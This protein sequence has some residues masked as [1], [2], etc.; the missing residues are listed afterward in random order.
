MFWLLIGL[1]LWCGFHLL[2]RLA[3]GA[4][5][6]IEAKAGAKG[7]RGVI[8]AG[9][10]AGLLLIVIGYRSSPFI[11]IYAPPAWTVHLNNLMMLLAV[12][13]FGASHSTGRIGTMFRHPQLLA[14][15]L[16]AV[17][18]LLVNGDLASILLFGVM[19][20]W[21]VYSMRLINAQDGPWA[22]RAPGPVK[23]DI[24]LV[25]I[26]L[27]VFGVIAMIHTLLGYSPFP[28]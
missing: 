13:L 3:P 1:A 24:I 22:R 19:L 6:G 12:G 8:A 18:H 9:I 28:G 14:V 7:A 25:V 27:V 17:A 20:I 21:A 5:A 2:K 10:A 15:S 4:Y 11:G 26:T 23:K 16:W